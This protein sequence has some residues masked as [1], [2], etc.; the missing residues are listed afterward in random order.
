M[1]YLPTSAISTLPRRASSR[2]SELVPL[3][4]LGGR[5]LEPEPL[6]DEPVEALLLQCLRDEVHIGNVD[7]RDDGLDVD[8]GEEGDLVADLLRQRLDRA[9]D[10]HVGMDTDAAQL[11]DGV[12]GW[13]RLQLAGVRDERHERHMDV[14]HVLGPGFA[15]ELADRLEEGLRFDVADGAADLG[16]DDVGARHLGDR[17][18]ARLDLVRDVRD[19]LNGRAEVLALALLAEHA[20]P[21][22]ACGVIRGARE[23]LV[24]EALVVAD[25]EIGLG[26][27]FGDEDLA[28]L[29]RAHRAR[30]DV[31]VRIEL[32][33]LNLQPARLQQ[34]A[35]R[36]CR[37]PLP[38]RR[39]DA[40]GD[41]DVL[42]AHKGLSRPSKPRLP[43]K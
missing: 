15:P 34:P 36:S 29:E 2:S 31:Q 35:E 14:E 41:E 39:D 20:V 21:D 19:H 6:A 7:R 1:T 42:G 23:V 26:A 22:R 24:D 40:A 5:R 13:L 33:H 17:A 37:D 25:V 11:V 16:D 18:D 28:V 38:E 27:V 30:V 3:A 32:L 10:E 9:A 12:L 4:E 8:V 43:A